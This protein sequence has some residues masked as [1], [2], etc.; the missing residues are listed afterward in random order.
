MPDRSQSLLRGELVEIERLLE[1][2]LSEEELRLV[3][4][5]LVNRLRQLEAPYDEL[6]SSLGQYKS[7]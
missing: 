2:P 4:R 5:N 1:S 7:R 6:R 3:L